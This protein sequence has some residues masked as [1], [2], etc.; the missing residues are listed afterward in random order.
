MLEVDDYL[1]R[2]DDYIQKFND[3]VCSNN[4]TRHVVWRGGKVLRRPSERYQDG[5]CIRGKNRCDQENCIEE[6]VLS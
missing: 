2:T 3:H 4:Q 1:Q 5:K 6:T